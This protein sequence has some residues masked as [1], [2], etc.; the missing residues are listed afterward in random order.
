[1]EARKLYPETRL[2][3]VG[4]WGF[5]T[6][7]GIRFL[8]FLEF[9]E[10]TTFHASADPVQVCPGNVQVTQFDFALVFIGFVQDVQVSP[11]NF[12]Y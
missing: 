10:L 4:L 9:L 12:Y 7:A 6:L 1:M 5:G 8:E 3:W 11:G 2:S